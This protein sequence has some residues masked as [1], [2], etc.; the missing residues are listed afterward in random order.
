MIAAIDLQRAATRISTFRVHSPLISDTFLDELWD[1][2]VFLKCEQFQPV[3]AFKIRGA[4]NFA[5]QL[6]TEQAQKG[7]VTHSSGN[8]AQAVAYMAYKLNVKSYVVMPRNSNEQKIKNAQ[9]WGAEI[10]ICE[11]SIDARIQTA[12]SIASDTQGVII[13]PFDHE[14]IV[15]G[16][17]TVAMEILA[18]RSDLDIIVAP[19]GGGGLLSGTSLAAHYFSPTTQVL[20]A[21]PKEAADGFKGFRTGVRALSMQ[22]NTIAD[23][24]RTT[25]GEIP[26]EIIKQ[27][28]DDIWLAEEGQIRAWMY[29]IWNETKMIIEPSCAVPFVALN[30][31]KEKLKGKKIAVIITGGNVDLN[32]LP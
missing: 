6:T 5:L 22:A 16:Q 25:V 15:A 11:P 2:E 7:F 18:E 14:W 32:T 31:Q 27:H 19:L 20:G 13:P 17:A 10:I 3:G 21:E 28:V 8:H 23:G 30:A 12:E 9:K 26:F 24:L 1:C 4:A 29:R